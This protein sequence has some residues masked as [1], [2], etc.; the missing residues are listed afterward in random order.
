MSQGNGPQDEEY[1][2]NEAPT[3]QVRIPKQD[4]PRQFGLPGQRHS[5]SGQPAAGGQQQPGSQQPEQ[6][7]QP[8]QSAP[9]YDDRSAPQQ[10]QPYDSHQ[11]E[12]QSGESQPRS[13]Y[14]GGQDQGYSNDQ[15]R[16]QGQSYGQGPDQNYGQDENRSY[17]R[18]A[19][20]HQSWNEPENRQPSWNHE[21]PDQPSSYGQQPSWG[22]GQ[23]ERQGYEQ[24]RAAEQD[25]Q[26]QQYSNQQYGGQ[27]GYAPQQ[28]GGQQYGN[29]QYANQQYPNQQAPAAYA[30]GEPNPQASKL[31]RI[32]AI[33]LAVAGVL[34]IVGALGTWAKVSVNMPMFGEIHSTVSGIGSQSSN[35]PSAGGGSS[36][37]G[38]TNDVKDG[39]FVIVAAVIALAAAVAMFLRKF[40]RPAGIVAAVMGLIIVAI[41]IYD[42]SDISDKLGKLKDQ[43]AAQSSDVSVSAG[44]GWGLWLA[45]LGG[46]AI[47]G[48]GIFG[49]V[50]GDK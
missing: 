41:T 7:Q 20:G 45:M 1:D 48:V 39:W 35:V 40:A 32:L 46:I 11:R 50:K 16:A 12:P 27:Q 25:A 3:M 22:G 31:G 17:G 13:G 23:P 44:T 26:A 21:Q 28:Y 6:R 9:S 14:G 33:A 24:G 43:A 18:P 36:A 10:G 2:A 29:Q 15:S 19:Q 5:G 34:A 49:A 37:T 38:N 4:Q 42:W 8:S 47:L 30:T